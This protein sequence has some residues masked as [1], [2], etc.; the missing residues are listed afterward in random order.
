[1]LCDGKPAALGVVLRKDGYILTK[2]SEIGGKLTCKVGGREFP[3]TIVK[4]D[5]EHDL[6]LL[7]VDENSLPPIAWAEGDS[8]P[9]GAWL[10][11]PDAGGKPLGVGIVGVAARHIPQTPRI[12]LQNR[13]T[14]GVRL[15][16][17]APY[18]RV[19]DVTPGG[20]AEKAGLKVD[21]MIVDF[22]GKDM[23]NPAAVGRILAA[24]QPGDKLTLEIRRGNKTVKPVVVLAPS[25]QLAP[26]LSGPPARALATLSQAGGSISIR[27]SNFPTALT[28]D[29]VLQAAQCGGPVLDLDG[30]AIGL[31]IA[32][33]DR[34]A[35]YAIPATA[36]QPVIAG[37]MNGIK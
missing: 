31:N 33:A 3:A 13:A 6:A 25:D 37:L 4:N 28:H 16:Y 11:T 14:L 8:L 30:R 29:T 15:E 26:L 1:V 24:H 2:A 20:P 5:D 21:D 27:H 23:P 12:L 19:I 35:C 18:A 36:L 17:S 7:K 9:L 10:V 34:T 32:R 22:D